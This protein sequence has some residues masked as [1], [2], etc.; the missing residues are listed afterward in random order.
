[1]RFAA[2]FAVLVL[3]AAACACPVCFGT[4][5]NNQGLASGIWWGIMILLTVTLTLVAAIG[6]TVWSIER[7]RKKAGG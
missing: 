3:P 6:C 4:L 5:V 1:M 2:T 7:R